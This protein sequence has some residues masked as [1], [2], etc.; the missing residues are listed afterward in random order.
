MMGC[1]IRN[2]ALMISVCLISGFTYAANCDCTQKVGK[3]SGA[4][5]FLKKFG[6]PP[7]YGAEFE[8]YSSEKTCSKVEYFIDNLPR[9]TVLSNKNKEVE[10]T[11]GTKPI[12]QDS[13]VYSSCFICKNL[14]NNDNQVNV[15]NS[16]KE[17]ESPFNGRWVA[18]D[19]NIMGF[20]NT[21]TY[22][23]SVKNNSLTGSYSGKTG[24]GALTG[25]VN[26]NKAVVSCSGCFTVKW[27][28]IDENTIKYTYPF[29]SGIIRKN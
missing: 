20:T 27:D 22:D 19:R 6:S 11:F 8:V 21:T 2:S 14:D 23:V 13:I 28:L 15:E 3:C 5:N 26:G 10:S 24:S 12:T 17:S 9:Q 16:R 4:I 29:G 25:T 18:T 1:L 7:S